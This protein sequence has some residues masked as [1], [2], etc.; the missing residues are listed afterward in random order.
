[1]PQLDGLGALPQI[2]A[3]APGVQVVM[4]STLTQRN[5]KVTIEALAKGAADYVPKPEA[6]SLVGAD[7]FKRELLGKVIALGTAAQARGGRLAPAGT[8]PASAAPPVGTPVRSLAPTP[9]ATAARP[10]QVVGIRPSPG[11]VSAAGRAEV[12]VIG[13]S[14]GGP[15]AL[16]T[17][18]TALAGRV[19]VPILIAQHMP[20]MF[21]A[22][23]AEHL[24]RASSAPC[25]EARDGMPIK[26]GTIYVAPGDFHLTVVRRHGALVCGL[27]Q[28]PP[29]NFCR[30]AVDPLFKSAVQTFGARVLGVVLTGMGS[31]GAGGAADIVKAG[32]SVIA[33][34]EAT[35][36]VWGMPGAVARAG[37]AA[38][39]KPLP[40]IAPAILALLSGARP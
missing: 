30:P 34:D 16:Q 17:L 23:M 29:V 28:S 36:V 12:V 21:T 4:A 31:D 26:A 33:Q 38:A 11:P 14:T 5:A 6:G 1:M 27:D 40:D 37:L 39:I 7:I 3:A 15:Q 25:V 22:I 13:S 24:G 9:S 10:M 19:T 18:V 8:R 20:A 2:I 32:G 35:S